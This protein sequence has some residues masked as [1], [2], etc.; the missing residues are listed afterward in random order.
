MESFQGG[1][2]DEHWFSA[3]KVSEYITACRHSRNR[4]CVYLDRESGYGLIAICYR[5]FFGFGIRDYGSDA[6]W[7]WRYA[8]SHILAE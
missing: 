6:N 4:G 2:Q 3:D 1:S 8:S 5:R 7:W